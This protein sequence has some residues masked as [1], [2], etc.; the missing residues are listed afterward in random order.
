[1]EA[2]GCHSGPL[3]FSA[4]PPGTSARVAGSS[5]LKVSPRGSHRP[6][7]VWAEGNGS[8]EIEVSLM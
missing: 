6:P 1:M 3:A 4:V 8:P 2:W 7:R 5:E